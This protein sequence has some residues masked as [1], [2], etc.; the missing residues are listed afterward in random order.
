MPAKRGRKKRE[1]DAERIEQK[2]EILK[3]I[4][5]QREHEWLLLSAVIKARPEGIPRKTAYTRINELVKDDVLE[6]KIENRQKSLRPKHSWT[7]YSKTTAIG[8][9][10]RSSNT[11]TIPMRLNCWATIHNFPEEG[12]YTKY[13]SKTFNKAMNQIL[14]G[15]ET[16]ERIKVHAISKEVLDIVRNNENLFTPDL[17]LEKILNLRS[18]PLLLTLGHFPLT[19]ETAYAIEPPKGH[20]STSNP[21]GY[22]MGM[23][24]LDR[25]KF[26]HE[27]KTK[28]FPDERIDEQLK[29]EKMDNK[30]LEIKSI[31]SLRALMSFTYRKK[32][33]RVSALLDDLSNLRGGVKG[34]I[35]FCSI[36][37]SEG[38]QPIKFDQNESWQAV[39]VFIRSISKEMLGIVKIA[40]YDH[41]FPHKDFSSIVYS[42]DKDLSKASHYEQFM[43]F[44][45]SFFRMVKKREYLDNEYLFKVIDVLENNLQSYRAMF[46]VYEREEVVDKLDKDTLT[47]TSMIIHLSSIGYNEKDIDEH[48][49]LKY[50]SS[51]VRLHK[52]RVNRRVL[53]QRSKKKSTN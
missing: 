43:D 26:I 51:V 32:K 45:I 14:D 12:A 35:S 50:P 48:L 20:Y 33:E 31:I 5:W 47:L 4:W 24:Q 22:I 9:I 3:G 18:Q 28:E 21:F 7:T 30:N 37:G 1:T 46:D 13:Y 25:E 23:Y 39:G 27:L 42:K 17:E 36:G 34:T 29:K 6:I 53:G 38:S 15:I 8:L 2:K 16:L 49:T 10:D 41:N 52:Q 44:I 11:I 40:D 19:R